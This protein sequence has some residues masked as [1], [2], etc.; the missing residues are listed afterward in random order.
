MAR[1][2]EVAE[3]VQD[4]LKAAVDEVH[5]DLKAGVRRI[6][7]D[8]RQTASRLADHEA[9]DRLRERGAEF[10]EEARSEAGRIYAAGQRGAS[11]AA[12]YA[13]ER[14]DDLSGVVR[15]HPVQALGLAAG[16]GF[17]LGLIYARR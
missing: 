5:E 8:A 17:L 11:K 10:A 7:A 3:D 12:H 6:A 2:T 4:D 13:E 9:M 16:V 1:K 14:Y 15:R